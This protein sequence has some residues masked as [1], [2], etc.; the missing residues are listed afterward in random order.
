MIGLRMHRLAR[1]R[2]SGSLEEHLVDGETLTNPQ[3]VGE[4]MENGAWTARTA[5]LIE[6]GTVEL[7]PNDVTVEFW[8]KAAAVGEQLAGAWR[9]TA[10]ATSSDQ[11]VVVGWIGVEIVG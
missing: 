10:I 1:T 8:K 5:E 9:I 3:L 11:E 7:G 2:Y 4:R 6:S